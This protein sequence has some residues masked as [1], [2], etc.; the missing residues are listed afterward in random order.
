MISA[1]MGFL[2]IPE[3]QL[4]VDVSPDGHLDKV[5]QCFKDR[6]NPLMYLA[7][8][9]PKPLSLLAVM[10]DTGCILSGSQALEYVIPGSRSS[11]SDWDFYV[12]PYVECVADMSR[13]LAANGVKWNDYTKDLNDL[14]LGTRVGT[15]TVPCSY[16]RG[17]LSS[18]RVFRS[19]AR[20]FGIREMAVRVPMDDV[21]ERFGKGV[22]H[23]V[24]A[25]LY[26]TTVPWGVTLYRPSD[27]RPLEV[28]QEAPGDNEADAAYDPEDQFSLATGS[29][30]TRR[31]CEK[32]QLMFWRTTRAAGSISYLAKFYA[33]HVQCFISGWAALH[34]YGK[35]AMRG[36]ATM[37][38]CEPEEWELRKTYKPIAKYLSRG[39]RFR[40]AAV[41]SVPRVRH[42][43]DD[44][45]ILITFKQY[46]SD[47]LG[48]TGASRHPLSK[49]FLEY[50]EGRED[51][52]SNLSWCEFRGKIQVY[53]PYA[54]ALLNACRQ[55][56]VD[57]STPSL[58]EV[59]SH[60]A[61]R[62]NSQ[63]FSGFVSSV[64]CEDDVK[65]A[66]LTPL[67]RAGAR[68][69]GLPHAHNGSYVL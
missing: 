13:I 47:A 42:A 69:L 34:M 57:A 54:D 56:T 48:V 7:P 20:F 12:P 33:T 23:A 14:V 19:G 22:R 45:A 27:G 63:V 25:A 26:D 15:V 44:E 40:K 9:F 38:K 65:L 35:A 29:V 11:K 58:A 10:A 1:V 49:Y 66:A 59:V 2:A 5:R 62:D 6:T 43:T 31:G 21:E 50:F 37:W 61:G 52:V 28:W 39:Y 4:V 24:E 16:L 68:D 51:N 32:V 67:A 46:F 64:H 60:Q 53:D 17:L 55:A 8:S 41:S 36:E 18:M 30:E 3:A